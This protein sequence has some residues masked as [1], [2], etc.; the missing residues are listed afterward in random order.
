MIICYPYC[1]LKIKIENAK[2]I[3]AKIEMISIELLIIFLPLKL[4]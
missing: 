2:N 3:S 4:K 1:G